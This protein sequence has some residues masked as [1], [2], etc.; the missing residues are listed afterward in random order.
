[1]DIKTKGRRALLCQTAMDLSPKVWAR[2]VLP[3]EEACERSEL[4]D[5]GELLLRA[6]ELMLSAASCY[7]VLIND[8]FRQCWW[9]SFRHQHHSYAWLRQSWSVTTVTITQW[10]TMIVYLRL[11]RW[12]ENP[13][14][15]K[16]F[17]K[18]F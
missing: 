7:F 16:A 8:R 9:T 2:A 13:E 6:H 5:F 4:A 18:D 11:W 12:R 1:M 14:I 17:T 15:F 3:L 10:G